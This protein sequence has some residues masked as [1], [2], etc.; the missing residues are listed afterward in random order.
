MHGVPMR[1]T[2][3]GF[4]NSRMIAQKIKLTIVKKEYYLV[5]LRRGERR[6]KKRGVIRK[7]TGKVL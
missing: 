3:P 1:K 4:M 2:I 7:R 5:M 6:K